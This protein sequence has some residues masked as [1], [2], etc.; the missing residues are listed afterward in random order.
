LIIPKNP[1]VRGRNLRFELCRGCKG[2]KPEY[3]YLITICHYV[4]LPGREVSHSLYMV[5]HI[6]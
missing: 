3:K 1:L 6:K 2:M 4:N 5:F